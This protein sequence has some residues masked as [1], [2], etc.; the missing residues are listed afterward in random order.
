[1]ATGGTRAGSSQSG[2]GVDD[3]RTRMGAGVLE[4]K[5]VGR[6]EWHTVELRHRYQH[7]ICRVTV[8]RASEPRAL[9]QD[10]PRE[11]AEANARSLLCTLQ[12]YGDIHREGELP[13]CRL[14]GDFPV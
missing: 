2:T 9:E 4:D 7:S 12:P 5:S 3:G 13:L 8:R 6:D 1:M 11:R 14:D 10:R